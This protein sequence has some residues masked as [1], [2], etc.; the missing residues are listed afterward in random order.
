MISHSG[1][2]TCARN[3]SFAIEGEAR[4]DL[5]MSEREPGRDAFCA[6]EAKAEIAKMVVIGGGDGEGDT[7]GLTL[8]SASP[9]SCPRSMPRRQARQ[10]S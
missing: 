10:D 4:E 7:H 3:I 1:R 9:Q 8:L 5:M 2:V 6:D